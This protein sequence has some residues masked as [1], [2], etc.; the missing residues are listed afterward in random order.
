VKPK[1]DRGKHQVL[2]VQLKVVGAKTETI[3]ANV[4]RYKNTYRKN[5]KSRLSSQLLIYSNLKIAMFCS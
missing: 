4:N 5:K 3:G 2:G 1:N